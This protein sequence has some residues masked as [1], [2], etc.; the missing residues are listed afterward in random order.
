MMFKLYDC[1]VGIVVDGQRYDFE[2]VQSVVVD[3]PE[4]TRLT[5]GSNAGNKIGVAYREGLKEAKTMT[6]TLLGLSQALHNLLK[7]AYTDQSRI[8]CFAIS[9][10]D[11]S[12]KNARQA[13]LAQSPKQLNMDD[14][15]E[16]L[17]TQLM[18]ESFDI[19]EVH[20][21]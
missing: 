21:S 20:K 8:D 10:L 4:R 2:H 1:D 11:G 17:D 9:R 13:V 14:S 3:D 6:F 18:F 7:Q 16:S 5:R 15:P 19:D 12:S